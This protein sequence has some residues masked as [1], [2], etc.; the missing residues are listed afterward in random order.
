MKKCYQKLVIFLLLLFLPVGISGCGKDPQ[1]PDD[2]NPNITKSAE[3]SAEEETRIP[4]DNQT[5]VS[6][7]IEQELSSQIK[8]LNIPYRIRQELSVI[9]DMEELKSE[10]TAQIV[11]LNKDKYYSITRVEN[12]QYLFLLYTK[13]N[14]QYV[15][16]DG[17]L[18]SKLADKA[19][20]E[21]IAK[22]MKQDDIVKNDPSPYVDKDRSIHRFKDNSILEIIYTLENGEYIVSEFQFLENQLSVLDY[23][24]TEDLETILEN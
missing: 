4:F 20:F 7:L 22:G 15:V 8:S 12:G 3:S 21:N 13:N 14:K 23:L 5:D 11:R 19:F 18:A 6:T 9:W 16:V 10:G 24:L 1:P 17:F 2:K